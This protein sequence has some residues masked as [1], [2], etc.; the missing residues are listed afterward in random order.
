MTSEQTTYV[1]VPMQ[2]VCLVHDQLKCN[3][4]FYSLYYLDDEGPD[5]PEQFTA[6]KL[7]DS[8]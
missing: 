3:N 1:A 4:Y 5:P 2:D 8:R 7:S 6:V